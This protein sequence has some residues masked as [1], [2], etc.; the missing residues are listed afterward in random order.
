ML[1]KVTVIH[2]TKN[3][4]LSL[5]MNDFQL[6]CCQGASKSTN[7]RQ[8]NRQF[9]IKQIRH[10]GIPT[11]LDPHRHLI[12]TQLKAVSREACTVCVNSSR[13]RSLQTLREGGKAMWPPRAFKLKGCAGQAWRL[14]WC[15]PRQCWYISTERSGGSPAPGHRPPDR[16]TH[17]H[18]SSE[19]LMKSLTSNYHKM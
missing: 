14:H 16:Q 5:K 6:F 19:M 11:I 12:W 15:K 13:H 2:V 17:T 10:H 3:G 7:T 8:A 1:L 9:C 18:Y 4:Q